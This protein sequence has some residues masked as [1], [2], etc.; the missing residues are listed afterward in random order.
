MDIRYRF[1][2]ITVASSVLLLGQFFYVFK[3][4]QSER[5]SVEISE[6]RGRAVRGWDTLMDRHVRD[7][8]RQ[9][10]RLTRDRDVLQA[11]QQG[12]YRWLAVSIEPFVDEYEEEFGDLSVL[13]ADA[14]GRVAY[15]TQ[16]YFEQELAHISEP[17]AYRSPSTIKG[18]LETEEGGLAIH[19]HIP[20]VLDDEVVGQFVF[21]TSLTG[22]LAEYW[23]TAGY[24]VVLINPL[25]MAVDGSMPGVE[26]S[27]AFTAAVDV[28][29]RAQEDGL[30]SVGEAHF[31]AIQ[32]SLS[33]LDP[34]AAPYALLFLKDVGD[35]LAQTGQEQRET[36]INLMLGFLLI[37]TVAYLLT[38]RTSGR[39]NVERA[40]QIQALQTAN[41]A[42]DEYAEALK[43][44]NRELEDEVNARLAAAVALQESE[45]RHR[46]VVD[47]ALDA[48]IVA[49]TRGRIE[50]FNPAAEELFGYR[51]E[52][53]IGEDL[54][55]LIPEE[56]KSPHDQGFERRVQTGGQ[57]LDGKIAELQAKRSD[58]KTFPVGLLVSSF[59]I[60][61][62][63]RFLGVLRDNTEIKG[64]YL[65]LQQEHGKLATAN[66]QLEDSHQQLLQS[67]KMASVGVLAAGVAHEINNPMAFVAS[68]IRELR[69]YVDGFL[70]VMHA[71]EKAAGDGPEAQVRLEEARR[72]RANLEID[73]LEEDVSGLLDECDDGAKRV[74]QIVSDLKSFARKDEVEFRDTN[75]NDAIDST[76]NIARNEIKY[77]CKIV[78]EYGDLPPVR[79]VESQLNQ[80]FLNLLVNAAQAIKESGVI[81]I[82]T[83]HEADNIWVSISD[84]GE[85]IPEERLGQIF[86]PFFTTKPVGK[87]TG[88]GLSLSYGIVERH[89]GRLEVESE[90]GKGTTFRM[91][92]PVA[93]PDSSQDAA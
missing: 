83:G 9:S 67:E 63:K 23:V 75:I 77:H 85:G 2:L 18:L 70:R 41:N 25:G 3:Q 34:N 51:S 30:L 50:L 64:A 66:S 20:A 87:G 38:V 81:T 44:K 28:W 17:D 6:L 7:I 1:L 49:D 86:D 27:P 46:A 5:E 22:V 31:V 13:V 78:K 42:K 56:S 21:R 48:I 57:P 47:N 33:L 93:G 76:L 59:E 32:E 88:L 90:L 35:L 43:S 8:V 71:Y 58:G 37:M 84:D 62:E 72:L 39:L 54:K 82:S 11:L 55:M 89:G 45:A 60:G 15:A 69:N 61:E 40:D 16:E 79:C 26:D 12:G 68:N 19:V 29:R 24:E 80:V 92:I 74:I 14:D 52:E 65:A 91:Q 10:T 36:M 53:I 4:N 73:V